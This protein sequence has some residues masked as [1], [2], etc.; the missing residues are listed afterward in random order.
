[1]F[2][3]ERAERV[4]VFHSGASVRARDALHGPLRPE[5]PTDVWRRDGW[6]IAAKTRIARKMCLVPGGSPLAIRT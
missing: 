5:S 1:M 4:P 3:L 2:V 6:R